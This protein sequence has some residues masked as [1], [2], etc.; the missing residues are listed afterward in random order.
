ME[1][2]SA[3][4]ASTKSRLSPNNSPDQLLSVSIRIRLRTQSIP[5]A[6]SITAAPVHHREEVT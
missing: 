2:K 3:A 5:R 6:W 1:P 4:F